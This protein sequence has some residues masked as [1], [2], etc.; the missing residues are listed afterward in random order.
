MMRSR[1]RRRSGPS[2][3]P[4]PNRS[5]RTT[6]LIV[7][8]GRETEPNYF[9]RLKR[10]EC[11]KKHFAIKVKRGK[12]G[13]RQQVAQFAIERKENAGD[14]FDEV[15]CVMD[16]EHP[17]GLDDMRAASTSLE[18][19]HIQTALSNP[20]FEVWLLAHFE[21]TGHGFLHGDAVVA[22]LNKRWQE[23]FSADYDKSDGQVY[24]RLVN[25]LDQAMANA[26]WVRDEHH[27]GRSVID[28]NSSTDVDLLVGR[29]LGE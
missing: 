23:H 16:V 26:K 28:S 10:E 19:N 15:W 4:R 21:K 27:S 25:R 13:S 8:E 5:E 20:A 17:D 22:R 12:G 18:S 11:V 29:L 1:D 2:R 14:E 3:P 6:V 9:D 24:C 7:C